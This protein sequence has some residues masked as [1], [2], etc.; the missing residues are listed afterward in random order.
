[1][2]T[3]RRWGFHLL[4]LLVVAGPWSVLRCSPAPLIAEVAVDL[5]E[6]GGM[7]EVYYRS[8]TA[9]YVE[10]LLDGHWVGR[11]WSLGRIKAAPGTY[12]SEDAFDISL[13]DRPTPPSVQGTR[14][15][16]DWRWAGLSRIPVAK[17]ES[18]HVAV[19]L[20]HGS[21]PVKLRVHTR[22]DGT[23]VLVRWLEITNTAARPLA[24]VGCT[25]WRGRLWPAGDR[26]VLGHSL[27]WECPWE[28]WFGW[29][30]LRDGKSVFRQDRGLAWDDPYFIARNESAGEYF[31]GQL[32][33]P[34]NYAMEFDKHRGLTFGIGPTATAALRVIAPGETITTP[35]VHLGYVAGDFDAAVQAMH[36]HVRRSVVPSGNP[37]RLYRIQYSMP[38]DWAMTVY[39]GDDFNEANLRKCVD[40]AA[41]VGIEVLL[42]EGP[43]WCSGYGNWLAPDRKRFPGGLAPLVDYTHERGMLFGLYVEPEGGRDGFT[44]GDHGA[45]TLKWSQSEVFQEHPD[46]FIDRGNIVD[47]SKP[48]AAAYMESEL[49]RIVRNYRLDLYMH[50]F[51]AP[52]RGQAAQP[53]CDG[54]AECEYWRHHEALYRAFGRLHAKLPNLALMQAAAGG[55]R[56]DLATAGVFQEHFAS[57][58][59]S[60]PYLYRMLSG[61]SVFLPPETLVAANGMAWPQDLPDLDTTLRG[62]YAL[63]NTPRIFNSLLPKSVAE[64]KPATREKFLHYA[65]LYKSFIRP[66]LPT[67]KVYHHAPVNATGGV[68][69]GGWFAMEFASPDRTK[70]WAT[71]VRLTGGPKEAY[72]L[73]LKGV[74]AKLDY[75]VTFDNTGKTQSLPGGQLMREGLRIRPPTNPRSEFILLEQVSSSASPEMKP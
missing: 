19:G 41:A 8:G 58:R 12:W 40:V 65:R 10:D 26:I 35:A 47:L 48:K 27:R 6:T 4:P 21:Y 75:R 14:L 55:C 5:A 36:D 74:D 64:L 68:E 17:A 73:R 42:V 18:L 60:F 44:S 43:M 72:V 52:Q 25:P 20:T 62:A 30:E 50:D 15:S 31:F 54:F 49:E 46:W 32:A 38:E 1:M 67:C 39:R 66:M 23:P 63:G 24:L 7:H 45:T 33:W 28:G 13:K 57:D 2:P 71:V 37:E 22:L 51:N 53:L 16:R 69:S 9:T 29:T 70:G 59:A 11:S 34:A 61:L 56:S 3:Q